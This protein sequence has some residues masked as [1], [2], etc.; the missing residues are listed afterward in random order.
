MSSVN[1]PNTILRDHPKKNTG[2]IQVHCQNRSLNKKT[3]D[4]YKFSLCAKQKHHKL[5]SIHSLEAGYYRHVFRFKHYN[6]LYMK[7][8]IS[9][10]LS[11]YGEELLQIFI[12]LVI[13]DDLK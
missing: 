9:C 4:L 10:L 6:F 7:S 5:L 11:N 2:S 3:L 1:A 12:V 13:S 8:I